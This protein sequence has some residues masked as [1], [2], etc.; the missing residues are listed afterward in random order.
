VTFASGQRTRCEIFHAKVKSAAVNC[1]IIARL[2]AFIPFLVPFHFINLAAFY[3]FVSRVCCLERMCLVRR[4][5]RVLSRANKKPQ[6]AQWKEFVDKILGIIVYVLCAVHHQNAFWGM[7]EML[8]PRSSSSRRGVKGRAH[9]V[10]LAPN[11]QPIYHRKKAW[12]S[13]RKRRSKV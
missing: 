4:R 5:A 2:P 12:D 9:C 1:W 3:L 7:C 8:F 10:L 6:G 13:E 11:T